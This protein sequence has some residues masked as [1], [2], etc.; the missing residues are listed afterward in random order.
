MEKKCHKTDPQHITLIPLLKAS[1][2]LEAL[3]QQTVDIQHLGSCGTHMASA[4][5]KKTLALS[6]LPYWLLPW[7]Q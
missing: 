1:D 4:A 2:D 3:E 5:V 7:S 6:Q